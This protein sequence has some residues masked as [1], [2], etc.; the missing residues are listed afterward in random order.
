MAKLST[1]LTADEIQGIINQVNEKIFTDHFI[2]NIPLVVSKT[3]PED[4]ERYQRSLKNYEEALE[5]ADRYGTTPPSKP[6]EPKA[7]RYVAFS[8][9]NLG[10][11]ELQYFT[12]DYDAELGIN[13]TIV[14]F[15]DLATNDTLRYSFDLLPEDFLKIYTN[16][17]AKL[18]DLAVADTEVRKSKPVRNGK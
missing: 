15:T 11:K 3:K 13:V 10:N 14:Y 6:T 17:G 1:A 9:V 2:V 18:V 4:Y 16:N 7:D 8:Y 5:E 12:K